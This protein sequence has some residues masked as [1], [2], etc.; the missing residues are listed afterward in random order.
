MN[1][2]EKTIIAI[3]VVVLIIILG[4]CIMGI[5]KIVSKYTNIESTNQLTE[6]PNAIV[7]ANEPANV[8]N[9]TKT[10]TTKTN[11]IEEKST[12]VKYTED[13]T[14]VPTM[15]DKINRDSSWC[16]T[17]QLVWNDMKNEVVKQDVVFDPQLEIVENLNK[18]DFNEKMISEDYYYKIFGL[19]SLELKAQ[20]EKGIKEKFNQTSDILNDFDWS[21]DELNDP[22]DPNL[23]RYFFYTMLYRKF[24]FLKK[25]DSLKKD[26]FGTQ[27]NIE[28]FGINDETD[29]EVGKQIDV[30]FYNSE[31]DFAISI[32]TKTDDEVIFY[33]NPKGD[34]FNTIYENMEKEA[35][36]YEGNTSFADIDD[37]KAPKLNIK[38]KK[39]YKELENK[40]FETVDGEGVIEKALQTINFALDEKGGEIKSEAAIVL[41]TMSVTLQEEKPEP[42]HFYVDDTFALFL[43]ESGKEKPYFACRVEDITKFVN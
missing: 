28:Y 21:K 27:N 16:G 32:N 19:K 17:F 42:R 35:Q 36:S 2:K 39:E 33:K 4:L 6:E 24:E 3:I 7:L 43:R 15:N 29:D 37:F 1:K 10:N 40:K 20:I 9:T 38:E 18:E 25:F 5:V 22:N 13:V 8:T 14:V 30:L 26:K 34:S 41:K 31:D 11:E 12:D 23:N